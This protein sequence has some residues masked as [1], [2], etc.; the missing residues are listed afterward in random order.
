MTGGVFAIL[1]PRP[2]AATSFCL[3]DV[4]TFS[5][6]GE[7]A[8]RA[9]FAKTTAIPVCLA[10]STDPKNFLAKLGV[11]RK[12]SWSRLPWSRAEGAR[13]NSVWKDT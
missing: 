6:A 1:L 7:P 3:A 5:L 8:R 12:H 2:G 9:P 13:F 10:P 4:S 11:L